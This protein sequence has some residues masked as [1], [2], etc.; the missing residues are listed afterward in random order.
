MIKNIYSIERK[1]SVQLCFSGQA[2]RC[3]KIRKK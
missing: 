3:S 1:F 2:Q